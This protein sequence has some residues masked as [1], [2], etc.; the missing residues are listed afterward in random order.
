[1]KRKSPSHPS[2]PDPLEVTTVPGSL[3]SFQ[4]Y[5]RYRQLAPGYVPHFMQEEA[6]CAAA[7]F[8]A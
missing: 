5:P 7:T 3:R 1:M 8:F 4:N 2:C 6:H